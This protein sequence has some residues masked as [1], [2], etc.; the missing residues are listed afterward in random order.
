MRIVKEKQGKDA[1]KVY[2]YVIPNE[3]DNYD[4]E[5]LSKRLNK[6]VR[7]WKVNDPKKIDPDNRAGKAKP[8]KPGIY[9]V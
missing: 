8:G 2:L 1:E 9:I 6:E 7:I 4:E 5:Q 3:I